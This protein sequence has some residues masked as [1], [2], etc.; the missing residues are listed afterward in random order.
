MSKVAKQRLALEIDLR[1]SDLWKIWDAP[2]LPEEELDAV[3]AF[4][5][6]AYGLGYKHALC[7]KGQLLK[8]TGYTLEGWLT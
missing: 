5:R 2:G 1:L 4:F 3:I 6:Y 8:D 7:D